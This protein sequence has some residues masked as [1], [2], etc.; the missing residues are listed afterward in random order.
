MAAAYRK[1]TAYRNSSTYPG[2]DAAPPASTETGRVSWALT[3]LNVRFAPPAS[4]RTAAAQPNQPR[5][6][7]A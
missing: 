6:G 2:G 3:A 4:P 1:S 5:V 7:S